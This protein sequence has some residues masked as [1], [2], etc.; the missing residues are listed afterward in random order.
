MPLTTFLATA[1]TCHVAPGSEVLS[2]HGVLQ[3]R[4]RVFTDVIEST[5]PRVAGT[6]K[7]TLD[8]DFDPSRGEG[9]LRGTFTLSPTQPD[10]VWEGELSGSVEKGMVRATGLARGAGRL[11]GAVMHVEFRQ[12][13]SHPAAPPCADPKAFF[14]MTGTILTAG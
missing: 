2:A 12:M 1:T 4:G 6:N 3:I 14:A 9:E 5:E 8:L 11:S 10:G 13:E 7:P